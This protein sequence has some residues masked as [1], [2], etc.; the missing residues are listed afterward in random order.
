MR[1]R[2]DIEQQLEGE[3]DDSRGF[4][5]I[6]RPDDRQLTEIQIELLLDIRDLLEKQ[7]E[8]RA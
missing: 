1:T 7:R 2:E 5:C 6:V 4:G 3:Y 8:D